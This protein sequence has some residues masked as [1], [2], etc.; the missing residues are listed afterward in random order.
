VETRKDRI[1]AAPHTGRRDQRAR[2]V[3]VLGGL[4]ASMTAA[5]LCHALPNVGDARPQV[6]LVDAWERTLDIDDK[7]KKAILVVYEDR[8]SSKQNQTLKDEL[9][10]LAKDPKFEVGVT[11]VA[12]ADLTAYNYW[13]VK[14]FA[15]DAMRDESRKFGTTIFCDWDGTA[16]S[17][18][19]L[20]QGVSNVVLYGKEGKVLFAHEGAMPVESRRAV[21]AVLRA[22][23]GT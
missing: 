13:P 20:R 5:S 22:Q 18:L 11:V 16:R 15:K 2:R 23:M 21:L 4:L 7:A 6:R 12:I 14:G 17:K 9:A 19:R 1:S 8:D 10:S 3:V